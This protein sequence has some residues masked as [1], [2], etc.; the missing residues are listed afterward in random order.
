MRIAKITSAEYPV[1]EFTRA[2]G[3]AMRIEATWWAELGPW[4]AALKDPAYFRKAYVADHDIIAWPDGQ[5]IGPEDIE[6][7]SVEVR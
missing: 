1:I 5:D 4:Y 6:E 3:A 2:D 7:F